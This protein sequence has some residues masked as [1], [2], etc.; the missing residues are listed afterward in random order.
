MSNFLV[1][2]KNEYTTH[3]NNILTPFILKDCNQYIARLCSLLVL[4]IFLNDFKPS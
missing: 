1:E 3:L 2:T 4:M